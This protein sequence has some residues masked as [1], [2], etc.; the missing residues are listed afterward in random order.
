MEF[1]TADLWDDHAQDLNCL[2]HQF[3]NIMAKRPALPDR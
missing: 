2:L 1:S 3:F